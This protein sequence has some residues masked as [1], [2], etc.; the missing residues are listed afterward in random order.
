MPAVYEF[1]AETLRQ[2]VI[3]AVEQIINIKDQTGGEAVVTLYSMLTNRLE[4]TLEKLAVERHDTHAR[5]S[6]RSQI[7][8]AAEQHPLV[9]DAQRNVAV[10][11]VLHDAG[12]E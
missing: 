6:K 3:E 4:F 11:R 1:Q 10:P 7:P 9:V 5:G 8:L 12:F 2:R